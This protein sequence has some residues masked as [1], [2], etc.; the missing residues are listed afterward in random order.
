VFFGYSDFHKGY[1]CLD[2][3]SG[4]IYISQDVIFDEEVFPFSTLHPNA[5]ARLRSKI[6]LLIQL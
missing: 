2:V 3:P 1:K 5:G 6:E 4:H